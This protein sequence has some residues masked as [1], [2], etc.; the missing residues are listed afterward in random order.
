MVSQEQ[1]FWFDAILISFVTLSIMC[2]YD[3]FYSGFFDIYSF[4][5]A[6]A[7]SSIILIGLSFSFS[8]L[9][10]F[11]KLNPNI[12]N[13]RKYIG[14]SGFWIGLFHSLFSG[15]SYFLDMNSPKP[16]FELNYTWNIFGADVSNLFAFVPAVF[17]I[18]IFIFM[19]I[20]S[21]KFAI[22]LL[23]KNWRP[24]LRIGYLA[25]FFV[26]IHFT[27]K[28]ASSWALWFMY[29]GSL[30]PATLLIGLFA[31]SVILLRGLLFISE[32]KK[33]RN[34]PNVYI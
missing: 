13:H 17:G 3:Y 7:N 9:A 29:P 11:F 27:I 28:R 6:A 26:I 32:I 24:A 23:G 30:P 4:N 31:W 18:I 14:L 2:I 8:G 33:A 16:A 21:N 5:K 15:Y 20:I 22:K 25:Y 34:V 1:K 10:H 19:A 12:F